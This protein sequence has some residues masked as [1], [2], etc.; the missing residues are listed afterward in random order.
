MILAHEN[1]SG[2]LGHLSYGG[3]LSM[4]R[5]YEEDNRASIVYIARNKVNCKEYIGITRLT[6][7][8]RQQKHLTNALAGHGGK[9][10]AAI[11][12]Y[13]TEA[14]RFS[15]LRRCASYKEALDCEREFI[16]SIGPAYNMTWGGEGVLGHRHSDETKR[17]MSEA[18]KGRSPW[19]AGQYPAEVRAKISAHSRGRRFN[20]SEEIKAKIRANAK[21]ANEGRQRPVVCLTDGLAFR[22]ATEAGR[23]Y[24]TTNATILNGCNGRFNNRKGLRFAYVEE[25]YK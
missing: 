17:K 7:E 14:F 24:G 11:R 13:G 10:Y 1:G 16:G 4:S 19:P 8:A 9:F 3:W 23:Y 2:T 18:K 5:A 20:H 21:K 25:A 12:K 6:L 22:S 15:V